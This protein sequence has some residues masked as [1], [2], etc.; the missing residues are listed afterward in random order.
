MKRGSTWLCNYVKRTGKE[1]KQKK[2][3]IDSEGRK[4]ETRNLN[5]A[6]NYAMQMLPTLQI[7]NTPPITL[8]IAIWLSSSI[9]CLVRSPF[10]TTASRRI[11]SLHNL[12]YPGP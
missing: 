5:R 4:E 7:H 8:I 1:E 9:L 2:A 6:M 11:F 3:S 10:W 12:P